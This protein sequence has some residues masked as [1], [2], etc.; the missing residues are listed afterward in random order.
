MFTTAGYLPNSG[1]KVATSQLRKLTDKMADE[2]NAGDRPCYYRLPSAMQ[3]S[4]SHAEVVYTSKPQ[5][6]FHHSN[7]YFCLVFGYIDENNASNFPVGVSLF[8]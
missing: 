2:G 1:S 6:P 5:P 4:I 8:F 3:K 7:H